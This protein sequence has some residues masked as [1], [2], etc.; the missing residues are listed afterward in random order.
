MPTVDKADIEQMASG[1]SRTIVDNN[2]EI[3]AAKK[4]FEKPGNVREAGDEKDE[5]QSIRSYSEEKFTELKAVIEKSP[6]SIKDEIIQ[7]L[8]KRDFHI[9]CEK[10]KYTPRSSPSPR[11]P[12]E[13]FFV[14]G[15]KS[16]NGDQHQRKPN[17]HQ[18]S[19]T[20]AELLPIHSSDEEDPDW[21]MNSEEQDDDGA[22]IKS[23]DIAKMIDSID[24]H[25]PQHNVDHHQPKPAADRR[26][27]SGSPLPPFDR[28]ARLPNAATKDVTAGRQFNKQTNLENATKRTNRS[29]NNNRLDMSIPSRSPITFL[30]PSRHKPEQSY[31]SNQLRNKPRDQK[32]PVS[33]PLSNMF[34]PIDAFENNTDSSISASSRIPPPDISP[35]VLKLFS[36]TP[37]VPE[38]NFVDNASQKSLSTAEIFNKTQHNLNNRGNKFSKQ[39]GNSHNNFPLIGNYTSQQPNAASGGARSRRTTHQKQGNQHQRGFNHNLNDDLFW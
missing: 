26:T 18:S 14:T 37:V 17:H 24:L 28:Q 9:K 1:E 27:K 38:S 16:Q 29:L 20:P 10:V 4:D 33:I 30:E 11:S 25:P 39:F 23:F 5:K 8:I 15:F 34:S 31:Q 19:Q 6:I 13:K 35:T 22:E 7:L 36:K 2:N 12:A 3:G 32:H 21:S